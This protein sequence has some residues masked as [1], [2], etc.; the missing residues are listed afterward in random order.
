MAHI[1]T[2]SP[3]EATGALKETYDTIAELKNCT[4][5]QGQYIPGLKL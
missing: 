5:L 1:N 3:D 4:Q 2:I